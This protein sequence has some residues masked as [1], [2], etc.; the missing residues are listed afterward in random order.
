MPSA[1]RHRKEVKFMNRNNSPPDVKVEREKTNRLVAQQGWG[2]TLRLKVLRTPV[3]AGVLVLL[4]T[5]YG[6]LTN[7]AVLQMLQSFF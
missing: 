4:G 3:A 6:A 1:P 2:P 7:P 5:I